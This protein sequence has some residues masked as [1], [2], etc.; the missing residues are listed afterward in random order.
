MTKPRTRHPD[1]PK[2]RKHPP[3]DAR[4]IYPAHVDSD[5]TVWSGKSKKPL[6]F[7][8]R[9]EGIAV[10]SENLHDGAPDAPSDRMLAIVASG[11]VLP[12]RQI[13]WVRQGIVNIV[14]KNLQKASDVLDGTA[15]WDTN[16]TRLFVAFLDK[17]AP[18]MSDNLHRHTMAPQGKDYTNLSRAELEAALRDVLDDAKVVE[19]EADDKPK[20]PPRARHPIEPRQHEERKLSIK[21]VRARYL[22]K[23][24]TELPPL[25]REQDEANRR[26][27]ARAAAGLRKKG[28]RFKALKDLE[29]LGQMDQLDPRAAA[30]KFLKTPDPDAE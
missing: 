6:K 23:E 18:R 26:Q 11:A 25:T 30:E 2:V 13:A 5:G 27:A 1:E 4:G 8:S 19:A 7:A 14:E 17:V 15:K 28:E 24:P 12:P 22:E 10:R 20:K 21:K 29:L 3:K 9:E 16:Q